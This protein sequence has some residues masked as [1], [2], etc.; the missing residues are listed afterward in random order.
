MSAYS[1]HTVG[2]FSAYLQPILSRSENLTFQSPE[3]RP[4]SLLAV[5][6]F[7]SAPG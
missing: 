2:P 5:I 6:Y 4:S 1:E 3:E 7:N